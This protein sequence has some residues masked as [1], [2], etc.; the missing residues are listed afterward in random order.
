M[1]MAYVRIAKGVKVSGKVAIY[2]GTLPFILLIVLII[3]G[4]FLPGAMNGLAYIL[5]PDFSKVFNLMIW[6]DAIIQCLF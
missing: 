6:K 3:R 2:T 1:A 4:S 5:Y